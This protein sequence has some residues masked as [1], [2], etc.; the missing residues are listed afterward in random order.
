MFLNMIT[1]WDCHLKKLK[2]TCYALLYSTL[3]YSAV[4]PRCNKPHK[5]FSCSFCCIRHQHEE[6]REGK[7]KEGKGKGSEVKR[8]IRSIRVA[9]SQEGRCNTVIAF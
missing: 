5:T 1:V 6:G 3:L 9:E 8:V 2:Q 4:Q 7:E